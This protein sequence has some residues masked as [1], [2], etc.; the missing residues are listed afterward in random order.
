VDVAGPGILEVSSGRNLLQGGLG[1]IESIG[2]I[3]ATKAQASSGG[4]GITVLVGVGAN[5]PDWTDFANLYLNP[6]NLADPSVLLA[7][8]P[9]KVIK[10]YQ[11]QLY[12]WLQ[13]RFGYSGSKADQL[14]Y[15]R[16]LPPEQQ[17]VFLLQVYFAELNQSGLDYNDP[18]SRFFH[19]YIRGNE[20]IATL[21]PSGKNGQKIT[22]QGDL[23]MATQSVALLDS[24]GGP[25]LGS[26]NEDGSILTDF[27]GAITTV[28]AGGQTIVGTTG[29]LPGAHAGILTQGSGDIDMYSYGSVLLGQSRVLTTFGGNIVIWSAT[30]DINAGRGAKGTVIFTPPGINYDNYAA[31]TLAPT[32][33]S[34]GAGI[35]TLAPIPGIPAGDLNLVAPLGT[36]D[37]GEAG[38][39]SSGNANI[40]ALQIVNAQNVSVQGKTVGTPTIATPNVTAETAASAAAG[41]ATSAANEVA[42]NQAAQSQPQETP[43]IITVEVLGYGGGEG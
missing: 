39:R 26:V 10:T 29:L 15:F 5:G 8:Q 41:S 9:G 24:T 11:D 7:N 2:P 6:A 34:S 16:S 25:T 33:P 20:A 43:S 28:V 13:Q 37:A 17:S 3:G 23:T 36:I 21:F 22:Y 32:V 40:A 14:S 1:V 35:G 19:S 4:A 42:R 12:T 18:S 38:I 31:I 27:G 30:G